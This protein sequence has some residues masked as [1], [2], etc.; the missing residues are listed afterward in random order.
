MI[1][2]IYVN[3]ADPIC[4]GYIDYFR[5]KTFM[6]KIGA[7]KIEKTGSRHSF[8][9]Q[10]KRGIGTSS[11]LSDLSMEPLHLLQSAV[12]TVNKNKSCSSMVAHGLHQWWE[13][14]SVLRKNWKSCLI[15]PDPEGKS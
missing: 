10:W 15:R 1:P 8:R 14:D 3:P 9:T 6:S 2:Y 13:Q 5:H 11:P 7:S 12:M 4:A